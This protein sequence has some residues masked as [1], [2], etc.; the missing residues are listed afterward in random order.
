MMPD[1]ITRLFKE[2]SDFFPPLEGKSTDDDLLAIQEQLVPILMV[3]D[4]DQLKGINSLTAILTEAAKYKADHGNKK[5]VR[6]S[7]LPSTIKTSP[8]M[9]RQSSEFV[10]K[11]PIK[12]ALMTM[13]VM[14]QP[15]VGVHIPSQCCR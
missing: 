7:R 3:I 5:F 10:Q 2:A 14:R 12:P 11:R 15:N 4:Y 8:T 1:A 13:P 6:P 9:P